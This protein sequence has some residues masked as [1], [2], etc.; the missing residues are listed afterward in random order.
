MT[1]H[2]AIQLSILLDTLESKYRILGRIIN[3]AA[4]RGNLALAVDATKRQAKI[5][6]VC[7]RIRLHLGGEV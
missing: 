1:T 4:G 3:K 2:R 5:G 7:G 6:R